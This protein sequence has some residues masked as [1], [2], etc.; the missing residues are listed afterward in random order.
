MYGPSSKPKAYTNILCTGK[1]RTFATERTEHT[2]E[3]RTFP[4]LGSLC[5]LWQDF[6]RSEYKTDATSSILKRPHVQWQEVVQ[7]VE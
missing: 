3:Q 6:S 4:T 1:N 2:E 5:A 7:C